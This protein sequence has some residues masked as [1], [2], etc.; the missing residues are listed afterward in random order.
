M[1]NRISRS[2]T[3]RGRAD[4]AQCETS[5]GGQQQHPAADDDD[6]AEEARNETHRVRE[7]VCEHVEIGQVLRRWRNGCETERVHKSDGGGDREQREK[8]TKLE[9]QRY[10]DVWQICRWKT[11][12]QDVARVT[13][14]L[15]TN[16]TTKC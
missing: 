16:K 1:Q 9:N 6:G 5:A 4:G 13:N 2:H 10:E 7:Q 11:K 3:G 12:E 8:E 14:S 15:Q